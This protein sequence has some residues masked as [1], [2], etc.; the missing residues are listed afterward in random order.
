MGSSLTILQFITTG[1]K[2]KLNEKEYI[3]CEWNNIC[4]EHSRRVVFCKT[5]YSA[6]LFSTLDFF[7]T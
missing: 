3:S 6:H 7:C 4:P 2:E 5:G 1:I